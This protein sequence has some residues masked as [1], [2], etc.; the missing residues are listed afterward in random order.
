MA[1]AP[2][3]PSIENAH[4]CVQQAR[5]MIERARTMWLEARESLEEAMTIRETLHTQIEEMA[6]DGPFRPAFT[7]ALLSGI[8]DAVIE[9]TDAD[10]GNIQLFDPKTGQ[11][12]I[13][14]HRGFDEPFLEFFSS[15]HEGEAACGTALKRGRRVIVP[16]VANSPIFSGTRLLEAMLDAGIRSVQSTPL[17][18]ESG[19]IWGMLST[20]YRSVNHPGQKELHLVDY[21]AAWAADILEAEHHAAHSHS[22]IPTAGDNGRQTTA[23]FPS[24]ED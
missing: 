3:S 22:D 7:S 19:R 12:L 11:L 6:K 21:F 8:L 2:K 1:Q 5:Q 14:I 15:V 24:R 13:R 16:D 17:I 10:K 4:A 18:G 23:V 20:H 9:G